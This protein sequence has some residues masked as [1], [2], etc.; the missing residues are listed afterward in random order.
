MKNIREEIRS[1]IDAL[2]FKHAIE[3]LNTIPQEQKNAEDW[4]HEGMCYAACYEW[5]HAKED[6]LKALASH[7]SKKQTNRIRLRI[8]SLYTHTG[9][10][11]QANEWYQQVLNDSSTTEF[12]ANR[13]YAGAILDYERGDLK[14]A[15]DLV[16]QL[17]NTNDNAIGR[18]RCEAWTLCG[19]LY[20][21]LGE[22]KPAIDAY[23]KSLRLLQY[24]PQNWRNLRKA[25]IL[26][27][28]AD[29]YEQF[30]L[31]DQ[32]ENIYQKA[33][34]IIETM[35]DL[36]IFDLAGY[37][38]EILVSMAN[39]YTLVDETK[40]AL[41]C[42]EKAK[43]YVCQIEMP[44]ALY[45]QSRMNYIGGLAE[46]YTE[47]P[48]Y[49]PFNK[50]FT[51]YKQQ[52]EYLTY[53]PA[54]SK[55]YLARTAYYAAYCYDETQA[56]GVL[57]EDLYQQ[58]LTEFKLCYFKDPKFFLFCIASV[59]NELGNIEHIRNPQ[60]AYQF[61]SQAII[62]FE[63]YLKRWPD[64]QLAYFS[65]TTAFLNFLSV[66]SQENLAWYGH[67]VFKRLIEVLTILNDDEQTQDL[68]FQAAQRVLEIESLYPNFI[69][70]L[71][72][73]HHLYCKQPL[74]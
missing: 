50:I 72:Q 5:A 29:I 46:L 30:E 1:E 61:Y 52:S 67:D 2:H 39:F 37:Q 6:Y 38:L 9:D 45:W 66:A 13:L 74:Q 18:L 14:G 31:Y 69:D 36:H 27:N 22:F 19:D 11:E 4:L 63:K 47:N 43:A 24:Y 7:P 23:A 35:E 33:W 17:A 71:E 54:A 3:L 68:A 51:A 57:Q 56:E 28:L 15:L 48:Q 73:I 49:H 34:H 58:A 64:D 41:D 62:G 59:E 65:L 42:L 16:L 40:Q 10:F 44:R 21:A 25:L 26:N 70:E 12:D 60:K 32:A 53:C 20:S 55:E 8:V